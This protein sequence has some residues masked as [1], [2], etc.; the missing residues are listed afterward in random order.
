M[1]RLKTL[2]ITLS[3]VFWPLAALSHEFWIEPQDFQLPINGQIVADI[4]NG[5][6]FK[7]AS[8]SY[9]TQR[10]R[11]HE[12]AFGDLAQP[13]PARM[14][15]RPAID[16]AA[17]GDGLVVLV[18]ET[19]NSV[20]TYRELEKFAAFAR[21]KD[22]LDALEA[23]KASGMPEEGLVEVYSRYAKSLVAL[24]SGAGQDR[25]F[26]LTTELVALENPYTGTVSDGLDV[27]LFYAGAPRKDAQIEVFERAPDDSVSISTVRTDDAGRATVRVRP[28]HTYM[29]DAVVLRRANDE[30]AAERNAVWESLWANLT[31]SVPG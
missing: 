8:L 27:A 19:E 6:E 16:M 29:L 9:L 1:I 3:A 11:R 5:E 23:Q 31:F 10:V 7:G 25:N 4:K 14:G 2:L 13:V 21:H 18:H 20:I 30:L 15:D 28:G 12:F 22:A 24:G 26:G 17:P